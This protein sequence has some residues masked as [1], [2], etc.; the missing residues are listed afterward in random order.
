MGYSDE[1]VLRVLSAAC[2][3]DDWQ[4]VAVKNGVKLRSAYRWV[5]AA[6]ESDVWDEP[7]RKQRGGARNKKVETDHVDY[8]LRLIDDNCY[9]TLDEMV[10]AIEPR[11]D[12][13]VSCQTIKEYVDGRMYTMKQIQ[14]DN[15]YRNLPRNKTLRHRLTDL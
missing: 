11:F 15:N 3:D 14:R 1:V 12:V 4:D 8:L 9:L 7:P 13:K 6:R 2:K 10:D 5:S